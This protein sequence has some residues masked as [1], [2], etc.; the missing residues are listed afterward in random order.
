[1]PLRAELEAAL[2]A[3]DA[4]D[5]VTLD[6]FGAA[7]LEVHTKSDHTPVSEADTAAETAV[8]EVLKRAFPGDGFLGE[9]LGEEGGSGRRWIIDPIDATANYVR[10]I[11]VW[12]TLIALEGSEGG[13]LGV[14]TAPAL[15]NRWWAGRAMGAWS[16][17]R[18]IGVSSVSDLSQAQ[19]SLNSMSSFDPLGLTDRMM[20]LSRRCHRTR[21]FGDF[22]SFMLLAVGAV[23][24]VVEP[25][26]AVWDLA[27]LQVIVEEAGGRFTDLEGNQTVY[28]G[29]AVATNGLL[30]D[31][32]LAALA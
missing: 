23:D 21:G 9:E 22:W 17:G 8:R 1:M 2:A 13:A 25:V 14:V 7:D 18:R 10:G 32:V 29:N 24:V 4:A 3:A 12:A 27:P 11:P 30:H 26:A 15:S 20:A 16:N 28:S 31:Q 19:L 6:R 5:A